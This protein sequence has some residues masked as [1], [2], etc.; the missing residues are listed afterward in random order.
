M[1]S[2]KKGRRKT[3]LVSAAVTAL[4]LGALLVLNIA[5][6]SLEK[7]NGWQLDFSFNGITTQR[8]ET[9]EALRQLK[10]P[11]RI[12]ALFRKGEEDLQLM[13][14]LDRYAAASP[15]ITW[16]QTDPELNPGLVSRYSTESE[17]V[18]ADSLI[19]VCEE[20][21]RSC[22]LGPE[23]YVS[24][25]LDE[26]SGGYTWAGYTYERSI[27]AAIVQV[28]RETLP[29]VVITQG[30][31]ELDAEALGDFQSLLETNQYEVVYETLTAQ[32]V[33]DPDSLLV[34]FSPLRDLTPE[35]LETVR[36]FAEAGGSILFTCDYTDP[37]ERME[38]YTALLRSYGFNPRT[39]V[40]VADP[41]DTESFYSN[42][43]LYLIPEMCPAQ[44]TM[45]LLAADQHT[46]LLPGARGFSPAEEGDRNLTVTDVL[47]SGDTAWLKVMT[48][49]T[50]SIERE[51][52][53]ET[54]PFAL[55]LEARRVTGAGEISR[56][57]IL[58]CSAVM[59]EPQ[60]WA[61]TD[62]QAFLTGVIGYLLDTD[63]A[64]LTMQP[65]D[66]LRPAL[67]PGGIGLGSVLLAALPLAVLAAALIV[68]LPR[69][70]R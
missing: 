69:R 57:F 2:E 54:G 37:L 45:A 1:S 23:D 19:V 41:D 61:M 62:T 51:A 24:F 70:N 17:T 53:D 15:L 38:N 27:T 25:T 31:G 65:R 32:T 36:A 50:A 56:A 68:L 29:R 22:I 10:K 14:L 52:G 59:T 34:F 64:G 7:R 60:I 42:S 6:T 46:L 4:L 9:Q 20:N 33:L 63:A 48:M 58:G 3:V 21:G 8:E 49:E 67:G 16:E 5:L 40:V 13:A 30:H 47:R 26:E 28:S 11:V 18:M 66:A 35:E 39:G 12:Y 44:T 55:A 43:R